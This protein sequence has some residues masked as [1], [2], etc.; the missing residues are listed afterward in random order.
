MI[1]NW[2]SRGPGKFELSQFAKIGENVIFEDGTR[3]FHPESIELGNNI[4][5][6]HNTI[7]Q[8]YYKNRMIIGDNAFIGPNCFFHSAG[9]IA[10]GKNVGI[11]AYSKILTSVHQEGALDEPLSFGEIVFAG[12]VIEDNVH[13]GIGTCILPGVTIGEG[14][15]VGAG[16]VVSR[17][18][19][20]YAVAVGVPA[21]V[22]RIRS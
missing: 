22:I 5:V 11:A 2:T 9:N 3:V 15:Q 16:A 12:V 10:I 14:A 21:K 4:Y 18:I 20:R 7:L 1:K 17:D 19:P 13:I 6:G 8:G